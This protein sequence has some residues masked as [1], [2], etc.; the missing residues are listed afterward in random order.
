MSSESY[1]IV[2][3]TDTFCLGGFYFTPP[4]APRAPR[5]LNDFM[6]VRLDEYES[7]GYLGII[8]DLSFK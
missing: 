2:R 7:V 3:D 1:A 6:T 4:R 8:K 5:R